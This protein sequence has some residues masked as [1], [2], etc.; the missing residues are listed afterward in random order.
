M[1]M[2]DRKGTY[3]DKGTGGQIEESSG[4]IGSY[5]KIKQEENQNGASLEGMG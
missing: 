3:K 1:G 2:S 5:Y 4:H